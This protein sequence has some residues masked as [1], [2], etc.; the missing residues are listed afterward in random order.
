MIAL[1]YFATYIPYEQGERN[2]LGPHTEVLIFAA[3]GAL[4]GL[5]CMVWYAR[6]VQREKRANRRKGRK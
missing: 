4:L 6:K 5:G 3:V 2:A 1:V